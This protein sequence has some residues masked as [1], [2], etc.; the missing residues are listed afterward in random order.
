MTQGGLQAFVETRNGSM[1]G[2]AITKHKNLSW[3]GSKGN[4][5]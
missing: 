4:T 1:E 5:D 3:V 2:V